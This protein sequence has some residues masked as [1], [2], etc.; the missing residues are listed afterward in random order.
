MTPEF[1]DNCE[2][3]TKIHGISPFFCLI[4]RRFIEFS[5]TT[6]KQ[7]GEEIK[8]VRDENKEI[9]VLL[10][11]K[12][13][14]L[15]N[16]I[17]V[18]TLENKV[19]TEKVSKLESNAD[20]VKEGIVRVEKEVETGMER[21][22][23]EVRNEVSGEMREREERDAN[24]IFYGVTEDDESDVE[25]R[26][27]KEKQIVK[28]IATAA[29]VDMED[30]MEVKFRLG[31]WD[32]ERQKPRPL[33]VR[34]EDE[35]KRARLIANARK[36]GSTTR[37]KKVFINRDL[38][39]AQRDE[40]RKNDA[41]IREEAEQKSDVAKNE[42]RPVK[43]IAVGPWGKKRIIMVPESRGAGLVDGQ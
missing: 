34:I 26:R 13:K 19:L 2:K 9:K 36:L 10:K 22:K 12:V 21:A 40:A 31:R 24:V 6:F 1:A 33:L 17:K 28:E 27:D 32:T 30:S 41:K 14:D 5:N 7:Q 42:G 16:Q 37:W 25:R 8:S 18:L 11:D 43:Y 4:C 38:T 23:Q 35:E 3:M 29:G 15:E 39:W 20:Q